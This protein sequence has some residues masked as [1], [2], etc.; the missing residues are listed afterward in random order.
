M[1]SAIS[2]GW[3]ARASSVVAPSAAMRFSGPFGVYHSSYDTL[4]YATRVSDPD[5]GL[6]RAAAQFSTHLCRQE[7]S[8]MVKRFQSF[9]GV[10]RDAGRGIPCGNARYSTDWIRS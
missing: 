5:F 4:N 9:S 1:T 3:A 2:A 7:Y 8:I 6:H 10:P